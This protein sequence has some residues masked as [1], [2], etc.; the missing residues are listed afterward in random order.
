MFKVGEVIRTSVGIVPVMTDN[1]VGRIIRV[2]N[3]W[4]SWWGIHLQFSRYTVVYFT[5]NHL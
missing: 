5:Y 3:W 1:R 2:V 4:T